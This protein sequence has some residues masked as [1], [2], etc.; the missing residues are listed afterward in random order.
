MGVPFS[1]PSAQSDSCR[2][3]RR[4]ALSM[5]SDPPSVRSI[6]ASGPG[7]DQRGAGLTLFHRQRNKEL[8]CHQDVCAEPTGSTGGSA[9]ADASF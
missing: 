7:S 3:H 8:A 9:G 1:L 5:P 2:L 4:D 6:L